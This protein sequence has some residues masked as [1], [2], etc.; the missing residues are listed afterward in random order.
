[1][2][3]EEKKALLTRKYY[4]H[5]KAVGKERIKIIEEITKLESEILADKKRGLQDETDTI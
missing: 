3:I 1:M 4:E 5:S 2:G